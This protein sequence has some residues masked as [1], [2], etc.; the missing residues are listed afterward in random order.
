MSD[1]DR[2]EPKFT[3]LSRIPIVLHIGRSGKKS[4][5]SYADIDRCNDTGE[6]CFVPYASHCGSAKWSRSSGRSGETVMQ[7]TGTAKITCKKCGVKTIELDSK[8]YDIDNMRTYGE[9]Y[10]EVKVKKMIDALPQEEREI[11][12]G[13]IAAYT[14]YKKEYGVSPKITIDE[15]FVRYHDGLGGY[16]RADTAIDILVAIHGGKKVSYR[17]W[18]REKLESE[19]KT[20]MLRRE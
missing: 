9:V 5:L 11:A 8:G 13:M 20:I 15:K 10:E 19:T 1:I 16:P 12:T 2:F 4:H 18:N 17:A 7:H 6:L 14:K 3:N